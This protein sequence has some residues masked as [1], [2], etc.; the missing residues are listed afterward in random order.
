MQS[1][2]HAIEN[3]YILVRK[4][5]AIDSIIIIIII[6]RKLMLEKKEWNK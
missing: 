5:D 4:N 3:L 6:K 2:F 1:I